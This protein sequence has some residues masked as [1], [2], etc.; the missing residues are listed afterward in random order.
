MTDLNMTPTKYDPCLLSAKDN[1]GKLLGVTAI[2]V[3]DVFGYGTPD[4]LMQEEKALSQFRS[5]PR[6]VLNPGEKAAFNGTTI[7]FNKDKSFSLI[8]T[9]KLEEVTKANTAKEFHSIR[10]KLQYVGVMTRPDI[11]S[12]IQLLSNGNSDPT[13]E[14]IKRL[15]KTVKWCKKTSDIGLNYV[16]LDLEST[17]LVLFTDASFAN[18]RNHK[19]QLGFIVAMVDDK[20]NTNIVHF[21]STRCQRVTRSVM[22]AEIHALLYGFDNAIIVQNLLHDVT[23]TLYSIDG[24]VDSKTLFNVV[25]KDGKTLEKRLQID[26]HSIRESLNVGDLKRLGWIPGNQNYS[27]GLTKELINRS[28]PLWILMTTNKT[29]FIED[30]WVQKLGN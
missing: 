1:E 11:C 29:D 25:A 18:A 24:L 6:R 26:V 3:D 15:N 23:G 22:A 9:E 30:G 19:S 2:Q 21:G 16:P 4:F 27:D 10:A 8:Q 20:M 12:Q 13:D 7:T 5:K 28:H 17:K 14:D